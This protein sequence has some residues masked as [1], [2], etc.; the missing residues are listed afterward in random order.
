MIYTLIF[1]YI[2]TLPNFF[3]LLI[4]VSWCH[5]LILDDIDLRFKYLH[6]SPSVECMTNMHVLYILILIVPGFILYL[7]GMF[8]LL[9]YLLYKKKD[10]WRIAF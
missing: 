7:V 3:K 8:A 4:R 1:Y 9:I 6:A 10:A 5:E 2:L